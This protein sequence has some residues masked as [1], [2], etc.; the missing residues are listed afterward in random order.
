M[1]H[2]K[3]FRYSRPQPGCHLPKS[4]WTG[5]ISW[6]CPETLVSDIPAGDGNIEKLFL[7]CD[8]FIIKIS[9]LKRSTFTVDLKIDTVYWYL[10]RSRSNLHRRSVQARRWS[11]SCVMV[12]HDDWWGEVPIEDGGHDLRPVGGSCASVRGAVALLE[13]RAPAEQLHW[14][15]VI[16]YIWT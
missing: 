3:A 16:G 15:V 6:F 2:K 5:K 8:H 1:H 10:T 7:L 4:P 11:L 13:L 14:F 12:L 9:K